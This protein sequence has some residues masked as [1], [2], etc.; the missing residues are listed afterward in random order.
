MIKG[1]TLQDD[2]TIIN[3]YTANNRELKYL[4]PQIIEGIDNSTIIVQ[5]FGS[6]F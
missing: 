1:S 4:K 5:N 6:P 3:T 2:M